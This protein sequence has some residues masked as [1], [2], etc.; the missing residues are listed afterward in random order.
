MFVCCQL[1]SNLRANSLDFVMDQYLARAL[2]YV[3]KYHTMPPPAK[4]IK[5]PNF[6]SKYL[7]LSK[8]PFSLM[9]TLIK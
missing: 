3:R 6:S 5:V 7:R 2:S 4:T 9:P 8:S 1:K